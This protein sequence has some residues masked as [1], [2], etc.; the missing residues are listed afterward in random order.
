MTSITLTVSQPP[1]YSGMPVGQGSAPLLRPT[2]PQERFRAFNA[3]YTISKYYQKLLQ[4]LCK[5][6]IVLLMDDS[7]SM[8]TKDEGLSG[9]SRWDEA[10]EAA[11]FVTEAATIFDPAGIDIDFLE[12]DGLLHVSDESQVEPLFN[13]MP[14]GGTPLIAKLQ[15]LMEKYK[16]NE[17]PVLLIVFTDGHPNDYGPDLDENER[18]LAVLMQMRENNQTLRNKIK[19]SFALCI[20]DEGV[21]N[22]YRRLKK[23]EHGVD[24]TE[25]YDDEII[26]MRRKYG[27][28]VEF[29]K[30]DCFIKMLLGAVVPEIGKIDDGVDADSLRE[31]RLQKTRGEEKSREQQVRQQQDGSGGCCIIQ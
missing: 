20:R 13:R 29:T 30:H 24:V 3:K 22:F 18:Q 16:N 15:E 1:P 25:D 7:G 11:A 26:E 9:P 28:G 2:D 10:H 23:F 27:Q 4:E 21:A 12:G 31:A 8:Q 5:Y 19:I 17:K 6:H 14:N